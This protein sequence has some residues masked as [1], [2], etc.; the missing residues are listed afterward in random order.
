MK[1]G[2]LPECLAVAWPLVLAMAAQAVMMFA[3]RLFLARYSAVSIQAAMPAGLMSF[4]ILAFLQNVVAYSGTFVAQYSGA[5]ARAACA[6]AMGQGVWLSVLCV[7]LLLLSLPLGNALFA[8]AGHAP[9][10]VA[11]ECA[12]YQAL[13]F[14]SL[15]IPFIAALSGFFTGRGYTRLVMVANLA[16]NAFNIALDPLL[17]WGAGPLPELGIEGAGIATALSQFLVLAILSLALLR[18]THFATPR[19][20]RVAFAWKGR[21]LLQITRFGLPSGSHVLLDVGTFAVFVFL[22]G[23]LDALSFAASNIAFSI[24]HLVFAPLLGIGM[25]AN[26]LT[27]QRM[28]DRDPAGATRAGRNCVLIGWAYLALCTLVILLFNG[29]IL[30][31]FYPAHAPFSLADFLPLARR[32]IVIFLAWALF[33]TWN[34]VLGGALKGAGD[35]HF[36]MFWVCGIATLL[37]LPAL[38]LLYALGFGILALWLSI[39]AYVVLAGTGLLIR[40][41]RGRWKARRIIP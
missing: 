4:I 14:G 9:E 28:G 32:L 15:A 35:T 33:D 38:L 13:V 11:E 10:V 8:L 7:P 31:A 36:V 16:G 2:S 21:A 1:R 37:W 17:I 40:F 3:D 26:I 39:L 30:R 41:L 18:E 19:R 12:Y 25:A 24:N 23:R 34:I 29:P 20:R 27:G 5:G 22:T 6:R